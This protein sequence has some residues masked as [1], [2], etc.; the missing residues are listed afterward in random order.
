MLNSWRLINETGWVIIGDLWFFTIIILLVWISTIYFWIIE[1]IYSISK[2]MQCLTQHFQ[3]T[4]SCEQNLFKKCRTV[5]KELILVFFNFLFP[6][7]ELVTNGK[8]DRSRYE[9]RTLLMKLYCFHTYS[10]LRK[11]VK[12][13]RRQPTV[14][15]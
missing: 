2:N 5:I 15:A 1:L 6:L 12:T 13:Y 3:L 4:K 9:T 8:C 11:E 14:V 7:A 10:H